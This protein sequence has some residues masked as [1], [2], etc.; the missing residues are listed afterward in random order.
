VGAG[1]DDSSFVEDADEVGVFD[2]G[3]AVGDDD[4]GTVAHQFFEG[5]LDESFRFGIEG[6]GGFVEDEDGGIA[7][8][9]AGDAE[10]LALAT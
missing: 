8:D 10:S 5:V 1:L 2:G 3:E 4:G 9:S 7:E 6:G